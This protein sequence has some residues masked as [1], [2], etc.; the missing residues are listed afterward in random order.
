M[1]PPSLPYALLALPIANASLQRHDHPP[2][3]LSR[4]A[5]SSTPSSGF[6]DPRNNG[7]SWVDNV[8]NS[9]GGHEPLNVV[10]LG[11][12]DADVLVDQ[13][14]NGGLINYFQ[15]IGFAGECLGQHEGV[16]QSANLGDGNGD[17]NETAVM[18]WAY[19]D[20]VIGTCRESIEGGNH[21]RYW[22]QDG[23]Q[24]NSGAIFMAASYEDTAAQ[25][26]GILPNGSRY[27]D[28]LVG[29]ATAQS[30]VIPTPNLTNTSTYTG[31]TTMNS[32]VYQTTVQYAS[33]LLANS[34]NGI[35]HASSVSVNGLPAIDGL[36]A[37]MTVRILQRP[38]STR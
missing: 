29:N 23:S 18:R 19:G 13:D 20:P 15:S 11:T 16:H 30:S 35:N 7:G 9:G 3:P 21:F 37:L 38:A 17:V 14:V 24:A 27:R 22:T 8:P 1:L 2:R 10:I 31:Q 28:W 4:R 12:S 34:S 6:Y 25:G 36:V 26:H 32:Y 5:N 33:G